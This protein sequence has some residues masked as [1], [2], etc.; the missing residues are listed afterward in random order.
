MKSEF[1]LIIIII[2]IIL[3]L[4][5]FIQL[6]Q[7]N[8]I[9]EKEIVQISQQIEVGYGGE[10]A[11]LLGRKIQWEE[12]LQNPHKLGK[13]VSSFLLDWNQQDGRRDELVHHLQ[14]LKLLKLAKQ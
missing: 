9:S 4:F 8:E 5:F 13:P 12:I 10:L 2:I 7:S 3:R 14:T 11:A 6:L 1:L